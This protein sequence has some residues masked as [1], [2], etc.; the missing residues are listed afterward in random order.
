MNVLADLLMEAYRKPD[1]LPYLF[2]IGQRVRVLHKVIDDGATHDF[3]DG[4]I[5]NV[6]ER[7]TTG[8]HKEHWYVVRIPFKRATFREDELDRRYISSITE[9][10]Q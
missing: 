4:A 2:R 7:M 6:T 3:W 5:G 8:I 10:N 9:A 1:P